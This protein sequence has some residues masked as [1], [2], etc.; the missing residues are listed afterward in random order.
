M[1]SERV[2]ADI[3][4]TLLSLFEFL[5]R[6]DKILP[7]SVHNLGLFAI[8]CQAYAKALHF[9]EMQMLAQPSFE[10]ARAKT[11]DQTS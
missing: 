7:I 1:A 3:V 9:K 4:Q 2:P 6:D 8:R 5:E 10:S 11:G